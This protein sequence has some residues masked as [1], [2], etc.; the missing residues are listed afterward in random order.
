[1]SYPARAEGL[2]KYVLYTDKYNVL[3]ESGTICGYKHLQDVLEPTTNEYAVII[4]F[5]FFFFIISV[6]SI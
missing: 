1:M 2:G 4:V 3:T 6:I 5:H